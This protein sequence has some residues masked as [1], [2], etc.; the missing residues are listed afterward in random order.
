L[1]SLRFLA[2]CGVLVT[3][4]V[5][6]WN[7]RGKHH[8]L[9]VEAAEFIV[10]KGSN[11][12]SS[13]NF[14]RGLLVAQDGPW[15]VVALEFDE[16]NQFGATI[17]QEGCIVFHWI[18]ETRYQWNPFP[19]AVFPCAVDSSDT[20][21]LQDLIRGQKSLHVPLQNGSADP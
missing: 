12:P 9:D 15:R 1:K 14:F 16:Q 6:W 13:L 11:T 19:S 10:R 8:S 2:V 17:R 18:S 7:Y 21:Y 4:G 3:G 20:A 5:I